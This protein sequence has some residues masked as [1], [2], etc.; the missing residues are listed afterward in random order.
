MNIVLWVVAGLLVAAFGGAGA[1]KLTTS[2]EKLGAN[3][4]MAWTE[5]FSAGAIKGIGALEV[6]GALGLVL[7]PLVGTAEILT[8]LAALGLAVI[9]VGAIV[10]HVR[11]GE[12]QA[13][14]VTVLLLVLALL[15]SWGRF[16]PYSF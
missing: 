5:D 16:G 2:K 1:L 4:N 13:L 11:R 3:P 9:M 7:P 15:V 12:R 14:P 6:L 10:T 8:P